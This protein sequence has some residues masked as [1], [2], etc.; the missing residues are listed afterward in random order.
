MKNQ[1]TPAWIEPA[2][3]W[4]VAQHLNHCATV[5]PVVLGLLLNSIRAQLA[6][7]IQLLIFAHSATNS[8]FEDSGLLG[9]FVVLLHK[10]FLLFWWI[11]LPTSVGWS[12]PED[13]RNYSPSD[14]AVMLQETCIFSSTSVA[15]ILFIIIN[16]SGRVLGLVT[17]SSPTD[18]PEVCWGPVHGFVSH[19]VDI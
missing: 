13:T 3:F 18:S 16:I 5:V 15:I 4:F 12:S 17:C 1:L 7:S 19:T 14:T 9:C 10:W 11:T 2:T 8:I 6:F